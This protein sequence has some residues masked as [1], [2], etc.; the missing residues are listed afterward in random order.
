MMRPMYRC[1]WRTFL[2]SN[3]VEPSCGGDR[4]AGDAGVSHS[5][6]SVLARIIFRGNSRSSKAIVLRR[7]VA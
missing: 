5:A 6:G 4:R 3:G 7:S 2:R 1:G